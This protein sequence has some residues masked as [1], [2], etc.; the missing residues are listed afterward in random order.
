MYR[1]L[2]GS[3]KVQGIKNQVS[4]TPQQAREIDLLSPAP[5]VKVGEKAIPAKHNPSSPSLP[6]TP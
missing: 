5:H 4:T 6:C 1:N 3:H 2:T